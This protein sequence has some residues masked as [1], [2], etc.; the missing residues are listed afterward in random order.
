MRRGIDEEDPAGFQPR[1]NELRDDRPF[2]W[3]QVL[4]NSKKIDKIEGTDIGREFCRAGGHEKGYVFEPVVLSAGTGQS[5]LVLSKINSYHLTLGKELRQYY[6]GS[7]AAT[8]EIEDG[9]VNDL[10][11]VAVRSSQFCNVSGYRV[12]VAV[13]TDHL[14]H[15]SNAS[16]IQEELDQVERVCSRARGPRGITVRRRWYSSQLAKVISQLLDHQV[17]IRPLENKHSFGPAA[18]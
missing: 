5:N 9:L 15:A 3:Q 11:R 10:R 12:R 4:I 1:P 17:T 6:A 2:C 14:T 7:S 8:T 13:P 18:K 16:R